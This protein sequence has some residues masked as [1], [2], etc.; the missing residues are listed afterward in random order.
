MSTSIQ[1]S[2]TGSTP[3]ER[4]IGHNPAVLE[5]W[6]DLEIS[7]FTQTSLDPDLLEQVRRTLAFGNGCE[8]CMVKAGKPDFDPKD[9]K[10]SLV[11]AF[12]ELFAL[13]HKSIQEAHFNMLREAFTEK[14]IAELCTFIT[15]ITA[16]QRFGKIMN[17]TEDLQKNKVKSLAGM[18]GS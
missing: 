6:N 8:Y 15:F 13:D 7:L 2:G 17:L 18:Q 5:K 4:L 10:I 11:T 14:E 1:L 16:S 12:A 9:Q 3:F